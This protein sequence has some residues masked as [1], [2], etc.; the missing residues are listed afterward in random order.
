MD[1]RSAFAH[2]GATGIHRQWHLTASDGV[3]VVSVWEHLIDGDKA[4]AH[5]HAKYF[6]N[7][8]PG[9]EVRVVIQKGSRDSETGNMQTEDAEPD[10]A[11]WTIVSKTIRPLAGRWISKLHVVNL[12]RVSE[13][14]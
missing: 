11:N 8:Q 2:L 9:Q 7:F 14:P 5:V 1:R 13:G 6:R 12:K 3:E 4:E 10:T